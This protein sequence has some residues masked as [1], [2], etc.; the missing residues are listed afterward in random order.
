MEITRPKGSEKHKA[1][2]IFLL[3]LD[4]KISKKDFPEQL[5]NVDGVAS[6]EVLS[7]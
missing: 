3:R 2:A 5:E 1:T 4:K 7:C 6:V